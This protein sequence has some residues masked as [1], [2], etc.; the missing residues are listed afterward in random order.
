MDIFNLFLHRTN[1]CSGIKLYLGKSHFPHVSKYA[2]L[3]EA[4]TAATSSAADEIDLV[5]LPPDGG[6]LSEEEQIDEN[7]D[8]L[9][10]DVAGQIEVHEYENVS[11]E[12]DENE[13]DT[14]EL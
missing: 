10:A 6:Q 11:G 5:I 9:P 14:D 2:R 1:S 12:D 13:F 3:S 7:N 4:T 8:I